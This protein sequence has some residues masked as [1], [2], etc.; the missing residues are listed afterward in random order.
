ML[1]LCLS[2][3]AGFSETESVLHALSMLE[4]V[5]LAP[6]FALP[7]RRYFNLDICIWIGMSDRS[8]RG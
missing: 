7:S 8:A 5:R 3:F 1:S 4:G 2:L 6:A